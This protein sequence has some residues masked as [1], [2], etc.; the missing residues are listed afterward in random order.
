MSRS[1]ACHLPCGSGLAALPQ[2]EQ[3]AQVA[4]VLEW[5]VAA[6]VVEALSEA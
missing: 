5:E 4:A 6:G 1:L 3:S 2:L